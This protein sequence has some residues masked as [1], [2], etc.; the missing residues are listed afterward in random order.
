MRRR[1]LVLPPE[2]VR[3]VIRLDTSSHA[4]GF[5]LL[6]AATMVATFLYL[7]ELVRIARHDT[8]YAALLAAAWACYFASGPLLSMRVV[9]PALACAGRV[10]AGLT[11]ALSFG[12]LY[13][14]LR[15]R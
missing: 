11:I 10:F 8:L 13:W 14:L 3:Y 9:G 2:P 6:L 1:P 7:S 12:F 15:M 5:G 4:A